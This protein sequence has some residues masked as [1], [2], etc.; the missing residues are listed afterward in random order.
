MFVTMLGTLTP[1]WR[2]QSD[3]FQPQV[4]ASYSFGAGSVCGHCQPASEHVWATAGQV[5]DY[6]AVWLYS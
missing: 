3:P 1:G 5:G 4:P 2:R 6:S